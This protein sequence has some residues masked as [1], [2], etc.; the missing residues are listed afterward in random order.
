[1][2]QELDRWVTKGQGSALQHG[3]PTEAQRVC[4]SCAAH[5]PAEVA[6]RLAPEREAVS[7]SVWAVA[8]KTRGGASAA[9]G[10]DAFQ[11]CAAEADLH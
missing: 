10:C 4:N 1:M 9:C 7:Q 11:P 5:A 2:K 3:E 6:A 8:V